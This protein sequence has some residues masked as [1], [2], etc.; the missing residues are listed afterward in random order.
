MN[1][2]SKAIHVRPATSREAHKLSKFSNQ[3]GGEKHTILT[4]AI[5]VANNPPNSPQGAETLAAI[6]QRLSKLEKSQTEIQ[7]DLR[8]LMALSKTIIV[9]LTCITQN[10]TQTQG[11]TSEHLEMEYELESQLPE[12]PPIRGLD[13]QI[14]DAITSGYNADNY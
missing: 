3:H 11:T 2:P 8:A 4:G 14:W 7:D 10:F 6:S 5:T 1:E 13:T 12:D 9:Q